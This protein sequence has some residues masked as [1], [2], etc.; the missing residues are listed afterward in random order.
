MFNKMYAFD[1]EQAS[2]QYFNNLIKEY[3][4]RGILLTSDMLEVF[5]L[6]M[7]VLAAQT[8]AERAFVATQLEDYSDVAEEMEALEIGWEIE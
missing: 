4:D 3:I 2:A 5:A 7:Q 6:R 8:D 1:H